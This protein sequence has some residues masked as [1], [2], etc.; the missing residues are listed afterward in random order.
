MY[1]FEL[2][3]H[4]DNV[5]RYVILITT[6]RLTWLILICSLE[7]GLRGGGWCT[8]GAEGLPRRDRRARISTQILI[9]D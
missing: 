1:N 6:A 8:R 4:L 7:E 9:T 5:D 2:I 3:I